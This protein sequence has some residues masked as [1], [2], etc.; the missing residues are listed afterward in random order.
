MKT[1]SI[2][3]TMAVLWMSV[4]IVG[5]LLPAWSLPQKI[6]FLI[7]GVSLLSSSILTKYLFFTVFEYVIVLWNIR[8]F[9]N[10]ARFGSAQ[11]YGIITAWLMLT[12]WWIATCYLLYKRLFATERY[13]IFGAIWLLGIAWW[14]AVNPWLYPLAFNALLAWWSLALA[15]YAYISLTERFALLPWVFVVMNV[16][17][18]IKPLLSVAGLI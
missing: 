15:V 18:A 6:F 7:G 3:N 13:S 1:R 5:I 17:F 16:A 10:L 2:A 9:V 14:F 4:Q 8:A 11:I 12:S